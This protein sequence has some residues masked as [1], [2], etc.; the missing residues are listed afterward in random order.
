[1]CLTLDTVE[2]MDLL[3]GTFVLVPSHQPPSK[4][5]ICFSP[6]RQTASTVHVH[7]HGFRTTNE[8]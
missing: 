6:R 7:Q 8:N 3:Q 5:Q 4:C 1:M 2:K